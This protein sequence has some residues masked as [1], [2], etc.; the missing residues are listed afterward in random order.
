MKK[1]PTHK[2][3]LPPFGPRPFM[4]LLFI[5]LLSQIVSLYVAFDNR[6]NIYHDSRQSLSR[7]IN[8]SEEKRYREPVIDIQDNRVYIPEARVY[9]PLNSTTRDLRYDY[10]N[11]FDKPILHI[12]HRSAVGN[13]I[14]SDSPQCDKMFTI[15]KDSSI[16]TPSFEIE[17]TKDGLQYV[18]KND[19]KCDIYIG[20]IHD[21]LTEALKQAK[22]Y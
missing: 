9:L 15:T 16:G 7:L 18:F 6:K 12:S 8:S 20:T 10:A 14:P 3:Q 2:K 19:S 11:S 13:Q 21:D 1:K 4:L 5:V 22:N 17:P